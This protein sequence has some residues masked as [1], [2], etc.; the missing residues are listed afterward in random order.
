M[1]IPQ[2]ISAI[3]ALTALGA[4]AGYTPP[5]LFR[6]T[7]SLIACT[8]LSGT[9]T[10]ADRIFLTPEPK[11]LLVPELPVPLKKVR[12]RL[13]FISPA[14]NALISQENFWISKLSNHEVLLEG[15]WYTLATHPLISA[16]LVAGVQQVDFYGEG[17]PSDFFQCTLNEQVFR[18]DFWT[19]PRYEAN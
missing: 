7:G 1:N 4:Q 15:D 9:P 18:E 13:E 17:K 14:K 6:A 5:A 3:F 12:L 16:K 8:Q 10:E 19:T 2:K 11:R